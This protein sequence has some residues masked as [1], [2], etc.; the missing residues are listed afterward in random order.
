MLNKQGY[1][2]YLISKKRREK[3]IEE[4]L[5]LLDRFN[6]IIA[7]NKITKLTDITDAEIIELKRPWNVSG[8]SNFLHNI[9]K[10]LNDYVAYVKKENPEQKPLANLIDNYYKKGFSASGKLA[11]ENR[12]LAILS[13]PM[14]YQVNPDYLIEMDNH[15]FITAFKELQTFV[16][17][18]YHDIERNPFEWGYPDFE[19]TD[20]YYNRVID[21]LFAIGTCGTFEENAII[22][23][24]SKFFSNALI[25]R[26]KKIEL[27]IAGFENMG[28][29]V[30]GFGKKAQSFRVS[31]LDN[32]NVVAVL[33][34]YAANIA[35][36][37][38]EWSWGKHINS[39]SYRYIEDPSS[40]KYPAIFNAEMDYS[41][42]K[43]LEI[44]EW[45]YAE[46]ERH[47]FVL[48]TDGLPKGC[49]NYKK[50]SKDFLK[51]RQGHHEPGT[52]HFEQHDVKI[53]TKVSFIHAF[54]REPDKMRELCSRFPDVFR[55]D[56]PGK[57]CT[58]NNPHQFGDHSENDGKRCAFRMKFT[59]DGVTYLRCGLAN[60]FFEDI[61]FDDVKA[62]LEMFLIENK[63]KPVA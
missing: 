37:T 31:Y 10:F 11:A 26:H 45:L 63:I 32:P 16:I 56:D 52:G 14:N 48:Q 24:G 49:L 3:L 43:L 21:I 6:T 36:N 18:C 55:L 38:A 25:K 61:S 17:N 47:G 4:R 58:D 51:V 1:H 13:S 5:G 15:E 20:G 41:S 23:D 19:T 42:K 28:L 44:Q 39:L 54:E 50:G 2:D 53:G 46:A 33:C 8:R 29:H 34:I 57:C 22:V 60:F 62:I 7:E 35:M 12:R 59:L 40:Q 27:M 9:A 30:E